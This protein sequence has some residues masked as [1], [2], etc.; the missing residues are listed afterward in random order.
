MSDA[1]EEREAKGS[2]LTEL[3]EVMETLLGPGGCP[4]D[5]E[6]TLETLRPYVLE[7]AFEVVEAID[8]G[9]PELHREELGDLLFQ[10]VFQ[11]AIAERAGTFDVDDVARG[12][13]AKMV[14]RHPWVFG[15]EELE[16]E[17]GQAAL[18]RWEAQKA[19]EKGAKVRE[20]GALGGVPA[21]LPALLRALRVGEKAGAAGYD[22]PDAAAVRGKVDE[23]LAELDAALAAGDD[24]AIEAE[25]GDVLFALV[26]LGRHR[27]V[28]AESALRGSLDRFT[29]RFRH[30]ELAAADEG[31]MLADLDDAARDALWE[32]AK[33]AT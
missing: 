13:A 23:E 6:Q 24:A 27:G 30:A 11:S 15:D 17:G 8:G 20:R 31:Q 16:T 18:A 28:D 19:R 29:R 5:K 22:W 7:E 14:R 21:A 25:L 10:I 9:N 32:R 26:S 2:A 4:W 33:Q 1:N 12:I 3:V